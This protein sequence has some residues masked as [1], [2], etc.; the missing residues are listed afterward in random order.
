MRR[1]QPTDDDAHR[2]LSVVGHIVFRPS[3]VLR[4]LLHSFVRPS[5]AF[6]YSAGSFH[7]ISRFGSSSPPSAAAADFF[8]STGSC[9]DTRQSYLFGTIPPQHKRK[10]I[11]CKS[12]ILN[13]T[14]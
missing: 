2:Q 1:Q 6:F 8:G 13:N 14:K 10:G 9:K 11:I 4:L 12:F 7:R 3:S 5:T